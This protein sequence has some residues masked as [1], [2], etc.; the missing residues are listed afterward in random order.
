MPK[1]K[2]KPEHLE[3]LEALKAEKT[4]YEINLQGYGGEIAVGS[5]TQEQYEFW[6]DREDLEEYTYDWD[7][8]MDVPENM[9]IFLPGSW[10]ECD[11]IAHENGVEFSELCWVNVVND[12]GQIVWESPL[13]ISQ[14]EE[15][16]IYVDGIHRNEIY[17]SEGYIFYGQNYEK[18]TFQTYEIEIYGKFVPEKLNFS[19]ID[20]DGWELVNGVSYESIELDDTSN[21]STTGKGSNFG[22]RKVE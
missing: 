12:K 16:G 19:I 8:E 2:S 5:I 20:V 15:K 9:Q 13:G 4:K 3:L 11:N 17:P 14:L 21:Y 10:Y 18:G 6:K 1:T 22:V 7:G